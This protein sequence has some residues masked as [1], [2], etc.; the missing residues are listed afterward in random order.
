MSRVSPSGSPTQWNAT[1]SP[2]PATTW[3]STQLYATLSLPPTNHFAL[4][5]SDQSSTCSHFSCQ[6]SCSACSAQ[7][8]SGSASACSTADSSVT[9][10]SAAKSFGGSKVSWSSS[11]PIWDSSV[12]PSAMVS[13]P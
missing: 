1:L 2:L 3:R 7:N 11:S 4:G 6:W 10:A 12:A 8:A 9:T 5:G 13:P